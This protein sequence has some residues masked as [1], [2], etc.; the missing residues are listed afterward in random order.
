MRGAFKF[1]GKVIVAENEGALNGKGIV[2]QE[3][4][5]PEMEKPDEKNFGQE[6]FLEVDKEQSEEEHD[7]EVVLSH[8]L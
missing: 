6:D 1:K 7:L 2:L 8:V 5:Y 3:R 4:Y